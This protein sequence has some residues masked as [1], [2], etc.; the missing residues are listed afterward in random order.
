MCIQYRVYTPVA[1]KAQSYTVSIYR[2]VYPYLKIYSADKHSLK[3]V[4]ILSRSQRKSG[5]F[6]SSVTKYMDLSIPKAQ[7]QA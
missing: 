3:G 5:K 4:G 1:L 7:S 2:S 6:K